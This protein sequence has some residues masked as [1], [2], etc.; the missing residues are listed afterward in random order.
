[1]AEFHIR[2]GLGT[3]ILSVYAAHALALERD[4]IVS[5]IKFNTGNYPRN[6]HDLDR[7]Y[8]DDL[9]EFESRPN[10]SSINGTNKTLPFKEPQFSLL[11]KHWDEVKTK[12]WLKPAIKNQTN[13]TIVHIRQTDRPLL[14]IEK[15]DALIDSLSLASHYPYE[16]Y[17]PIIISEDESVIQRYKL[18]PVSDALADWKRILN[19]KTVYGAYSTFTLLAAAL[20]PDQKLF[21]FSQENCDDPSLILQDDWCKIRQL[22]EL[23]GNVEWM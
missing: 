14:A 9:L 13:E 4:T 10:I 23:F 8:I 18:Q 17:Q 19:A 16:N 11:L 21:F 7:I 1:M 6:D 15:F 5:D 20:N 3:Q 2:G 12:V 22:V